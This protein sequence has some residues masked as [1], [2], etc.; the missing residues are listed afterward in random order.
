LLPPVVE[1]LAE[2]RDHLREHG[3]ALLAGQLSPA[4][5]DQARASTYAAAEDDRLQG[6]QADRFGLDYGEGNVRVWNMLNRHRV[7]REMVQL[8]VVLELLRDV[9]GWPAL[10]GNISANIA[11]PGGEGGMLHADQIFVPRPWPPEPQGMNFAWLLDDYTADNGA[12]EVVPGSHLAGDDVDLAALEAQAE[13]VVA[14]A[15]TL[16][17]IESRLWHRTGRNRS[18]QPRA[19][20][21]GWYTRPIYRTQENWFLSLDDRVIEYASDD[22]LVL[23]GYR[24]EGFGL[25][26]GRSP[27]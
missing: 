18:A 16:M 14:P 6:R 20:L 26:Y 22:L 13:P 10:L 2:A 15:G 11:L 3:L 24:T 12:T 25:V 7:F 17:V 23:L 5:L 4:Q 19:G 8:P 1:D 27:R 21:F 9:I